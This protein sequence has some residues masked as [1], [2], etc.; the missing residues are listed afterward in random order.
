MGFGIK[1]PNLPVSTSAFLNQ[2]P[3]AQEKKREPSLLGGIL[4]IN[5]L[6]ALSNASKLVPGG[7]KTSNKIALALA[8]TQATEGN[9]PGALATAT[10]AIGDK[11]ST[12]LKYL[13]T[14]LDII[15]KGDRNLAIQILVFAL[16]ADGDNEKAN[17]LLKI[18]D[19]SGTLDG[20]AN[21]AK[22]LF[23]IG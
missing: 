3:P 7:N 1:L 13:P 4:P 21:T 8:F 22:N 20:V 9:I 14:A 11:N 16:R 17:I 15:S 19:A 10:T 5:P 12:T 23:H 18:N 6:S 2:A